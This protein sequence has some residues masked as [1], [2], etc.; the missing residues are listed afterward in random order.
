V[1]LEVVQG[2]CELVAGSGKLALLDVAELNPGLDIGARTERAAA[3]LIHRT[4]TTARIAPPRHGTYWSL[5]D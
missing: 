4:V 1:S 5:A 2:I 3:R